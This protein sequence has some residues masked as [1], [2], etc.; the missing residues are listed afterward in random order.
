MTQFCTDYVP[1]GN[2]RLTRTEIDNLVG[3]EYVELPASRVK[4][5][6]LRLKEI[7]DLNHD[8][9]YAMGGY[10]TYL[11]QILSIDVPKIY[12]FHDPALQNASNIRQKR[13]LS[14]LIPL[15]DMV[16][17]LSEGQK[18]LVPAAKKSVVLPNTWLQDKPPK[19]EKY[20]DFTVTFFGRH[21]LSKGIDTVDY[22]SRNLP[23][24]VRLI[25]A[26][27]GSV[28]LQS[29]DYGANVE[30]KGFLEN[31]ELWDIISKSHATLFPSRSEA[32][33][34]V[35][36]ESIVH[37]TPIIYRPISANRSLSGVP[38][39]KEASDD[40]GFLEGVKWLREEWHS[41]PA[42]YLEK[43]SNLV[44]EVMSADEYAEQFINGII[45]PVANR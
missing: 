39:C 21:E 25:I 45:H 18:E 26:G 36:L 38:L 32:S 13:I 12:G 16:H 44:D 33:S 9:L 5:T 43:C 31:E 20:Q 41:D 4:F 1:G 6:P 19:K 14:D 34:L 27:S 10:Y 35:A 37:G 28:K 7:P 3:Y 17:F 15:F 2:G 30:V 29:N 24:G 42:S 40:S 8:A 11:K 23:D 22:V